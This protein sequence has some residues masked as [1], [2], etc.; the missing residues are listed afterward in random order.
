MKF[1]NYA[2]HDLFTLEPYTHLLIVIYMNSDKDKTESKVIKYKMFL[3]NIF[4]FLYS[5]HWKIFLK[6]FYTSLLVSLLSKWYL[7]SLGFDNSDAN[8]F[9]SCNSIA[10]CTGN[11]FES[12]Y[13]G[14]NPL[15]VIMSWNWHNAWTI[16]RLSTDHKVVYNWE[17]KPDAHRHYADI[18][19]E[20]KESLCWESWSF[21]C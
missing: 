12:I 9:R 21:S 16:L 20:W 19:L 10:A 8:V 7:A 3:K 15:M 6:L 4:F 5:I 17:W 18:Y 14:C 1:Q 11:L 2:Y 13:W